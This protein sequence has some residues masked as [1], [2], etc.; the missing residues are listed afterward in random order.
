MEK[1]KK[2]LTLKCDQLKESC[3]R[4]SQQNTELENLFKDALQ[5][6]WKLQSSLDSAKAA[7]DR[8]N[9]DLQNEKNKIENLEKN[10][11]II[12]KEKQ[13]IQSFCENIKNRADTAEKSISQLSQQIEALQVEAGRCKDFE[14]SN[15]AMQEKISSFEKEKTSMQKEITKLREIIEVRLSFNLFKP[16]F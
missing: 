4:L 16:F 14:K 13:T 6:N 5:E 7:S 8:Q 15:F 10:I 1:E 11:E 9:Q 2:K 3:D 12:T